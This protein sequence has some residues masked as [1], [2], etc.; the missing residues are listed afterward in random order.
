M[1]R[2]PLDVLVQPLGLKLLDRGDD[3]RVHGAAALAEQARVRHLVGESVL[4][5]VLE[6]RKELAS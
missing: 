1:V 3:A 6:L 4:E 5:G 2:E